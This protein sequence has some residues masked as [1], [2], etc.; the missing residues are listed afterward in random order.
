MSVSV[1]FGSVVE[2]NALLSGLQTFLLFNNWDKFVKPLICSIQTLKIKLLSAL[3]T[4]VLHDSG[5]ILVYYAS[6]RMIFA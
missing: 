3:G 6:N 1:H 2:L 5:V 4:T